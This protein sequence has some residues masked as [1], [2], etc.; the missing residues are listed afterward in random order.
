MKS[1][2]TCLRMLG[3]TMHT[4]NY[5]VSVTYEM[6]TPKIKQKQEYLPHYT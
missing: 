3:G 4:V 2:D 1:K 6:Y 5:T